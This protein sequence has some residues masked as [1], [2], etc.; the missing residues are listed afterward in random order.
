MSKVIAFLGSPRKNGFSAQLVSSVLDG[1]RS[2]GAEVVVYDIN[3][4][5][6]KGC[7][8]CFWC[9]SH[10]GC[11]TRDKLQ[12][13]YEDIVSADGIVAGFPIYFGTVSG[14]AKLWMDRLYPMYGDSFVP[15]HP[16]KKMVTVY[17]QANG[18]STRFADAVRS[19][20]GFFAGIGWE[21]IESL[22]ICGDVVPGYEIP[23]ELTERA[24][25]A[26][27]RLVAEE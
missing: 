26:G 9:R 11:A 19:T 18:D 20:D 17:A 12:P 7:Q 6:V 4:D 15:R 13:M 10:D 3:A 14:Q 8:G 1:A 25:E 5:G 27:R 2:A 23:R 21:V 24:F 22:L 16:G